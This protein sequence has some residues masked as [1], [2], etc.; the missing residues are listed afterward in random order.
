MGLRFEGLLEV[1]LVGFL[2]CGGFCDFFDMLR[3]AVPGF[4][5]SV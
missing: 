1:F 3:Y 5:C 4:N 2:E